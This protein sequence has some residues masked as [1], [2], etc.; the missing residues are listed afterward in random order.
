MKFDFNICA[1]KGLNMKNNIH[2]IV[3]HYGSG[4]SEFCMNYAFARRQM[5]LE[6]AVADLDIVNPYFRTRQQADI[7]GA[8]G[9]RVVSNNM[10]NDWKVDIPALNSELNSFFIDSQRDNIIDVGG[11]A[12]GARVLARFQDHIRDASYEMW[13]IVNANRYETQTA[14]QVMEFI[15][16]ISRSSGLSMTGVVNNTHML[17]ETEMEDILRGNEVTKEVCEQSGL[18][19]VYTVCPQRLEEACR[20]NG[21][22]LGEIF[23]IQ[24]YLRPDYL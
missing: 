16:E 9:I 2:I 24:M 12:V 14:G 5:G 3:G 20:A 17:R 6:V 11:N 1:G 15:R 23:P 13:M 19:C 18:P 7:L 22:L 10:E 8:R 21:G 4:K